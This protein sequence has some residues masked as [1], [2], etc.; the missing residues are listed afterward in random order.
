MHDLWRRQSVRSTGEVPAVRRR[1]E[2]LAEPTPD[3]VL[4][5]VADDARRELAAWRGE[6]RLQ[7]CLCDVW[8]DHILFT[9][10]E[11]TGVIDYS[12]MRMDAVAGD[13][14]RLLG[15]LAGDDEPAWRVGLSEMG[16]APAEERLARLL[17]RAGTAAAALRWERWLREGRPFADPEAAR[18][19]ASEV[20]RRVGKFPSGG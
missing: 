11:V 2:A 9:E 15:S 13:V 16:L 18:R 5:R 19:R 3:P 1:L 7:P 10:G 14:A 6:V 12:S 20:L 4:R 17:D 8:H